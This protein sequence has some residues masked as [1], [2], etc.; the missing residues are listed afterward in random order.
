[1]NAE[2]DGR[3]FAKTIGGGTPGALGGYRH[4][5]G[6]LVEAILIP[7]ANALAADDRDLLLHLIASHHGFTRPIVAPL[8]PESAPSVSSSVARAATLRY[9]RLQ[10]AWGA[11]GLAWWE[12][13]LRSADWSASRRVNSNE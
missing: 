8:D 12:A 4:E 1:M 10:Q 13:L 9:A 7:E 11:W 6:S 5:F 3:P 2:R